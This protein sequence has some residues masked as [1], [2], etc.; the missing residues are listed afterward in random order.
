MTEDNRAARYSDL[1]AARHDH[2]SDCAYC[3]ICATIGV[4]RNVKPEVVEH[5]ASAARELI[6]AFG[7]LL[8]EA[9]EAIGSPEAVR[10]RDSKSE[11]EDAKVRR[12][13]IG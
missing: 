6:I 11:D 4:V 2:T 7:L 13:D 12:I 5:M 9:S 3:P 10:S 8:E 1:F